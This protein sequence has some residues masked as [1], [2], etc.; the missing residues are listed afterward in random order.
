LFD[1]GVV[2][3]HMKGRVVGLGKER[4]GVAELRH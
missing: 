3:S 4:R 2:G 1:K